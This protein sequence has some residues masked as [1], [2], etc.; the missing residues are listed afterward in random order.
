MIS[1]IKTVAGT[2]SFFDLDKL[3]SGLKPRLT[4]QTIKTLKSWCYTNNLS[5][6]KGL[7]KANKFPIP[8]MGRKRQKDLVAFWEKI[9]KLRKQTKEK[10]VEGTIRHIRTHLT[11]PKFSSRDHS[12]AS[13]SL[14]RL[15]SMAK[16]FKGD[17]EDFVLH[18]ALLA[19]TDIHDA[20]IEKVS[21]MTMH[22]AKGLEFGVVFIVGCED[23]FLPYRK[24]GHDLPDIEEERRLFYVAMTR[25]KE[26]LFLSYAKNRRIFGRT[27][28]RAVSPFVAQIEQRLLKYESQPF[29]K[30]AKD[31]SRQRKLFD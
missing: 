2:G 4:P 17:A 22:A 18:I 1:F 3:K 5:L 7:Q 10:G 21:L 12:Q 15:L 26:Q 8:G 30:K 11:D 16:D 25:A 9:Q 29:K 23:G 27:L 31:D 20:S 13:E 6:E 19:D 24:S 28:E 14:G